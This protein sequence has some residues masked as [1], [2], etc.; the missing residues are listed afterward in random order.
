MFPY[1]Q[2][3]KTANSSK[4]K[5]TNHDA[6]SQRVQGRVGSLFLG[7]LDQGLVRS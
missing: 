2:H 3:H 4:N 7:Q 1:K 6:V 5:N